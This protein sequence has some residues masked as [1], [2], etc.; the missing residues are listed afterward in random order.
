M[1]QRRPVLTA[2]DPANPGDNLPA[3]DFHI[4]ENTRAHIVTER[5]RETLLMGI[6]PGASD[7]WIVAP[8]RS[9]S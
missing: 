8:H 3:H 6:D 4:G 7:L 1:S 9:Q 2:D 5:A